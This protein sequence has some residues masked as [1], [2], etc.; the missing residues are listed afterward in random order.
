MQKQV[1]QIE[2]CR[3]CKSHAMSTRHNERLYRQTF[4]EIKK[5]LESNGFVV[6]ESP[7]Y[8]LGAFEV[9]LGD[10]LLYS[11]LRYGVLPNPA[12]IVEKVLKRE[13]NPE[14][15]EIVKLATST[16][17][18]TTTP[19]AKPFRRR[20]E[21]KYN[22]SCGNFATIA[23]N[24]S[25]YRT[26]QRPAS[27]IGN[28][29]P[30]KAFF[31]SRKINSHKYIE[32]YRPELLVTLHRVRPQSSMDRHMTTTQPSSSGFGKTA[33]SHDKNSGISKAEMSSSMLHLLDNAPDLASF[34][35][36]NRLRTSQL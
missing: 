29:I 30:L 6:V 27:T 13:N 17:W 18:T 20:I 32:G 31:S 28:T 24:K 3:K 1:V 12:A 22:R 21:R 33:Y 10:W 36:G 26:H 19:T 8:R 25:T 2:Y 9:H 14:E 15:K 5:A 7:A 4:D 35:G 23:S 11:K 34:R 16:N